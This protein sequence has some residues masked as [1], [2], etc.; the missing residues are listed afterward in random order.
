MT[1]NGDMKS[2]KIQAVRGLAIIAVVFIHTAPGGMTQVICRPF[3]NIAV[4]SFLFL[5]GMLSDAKRWHPMKRLKKIWIPYMIWTFVYSL[6]LSYKCPD[7]I[8]RNFFH[9]LFLLT[10][11]QGSAPFTA[12]AKGSSSPSATQGQSCLYTAAPDRDSFLPGIA[13]HNDP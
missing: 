13:G 3:L 9:S 10:M 2:T 1:P 11:R 7:Q 4:G 6:A 8:I 12:R 5:S